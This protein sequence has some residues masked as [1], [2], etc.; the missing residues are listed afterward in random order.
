MGAGD[1]THLPKVLPDKTSLLIRPGNYVFGPF[2]ANDNSKKKYETHHQTSHQEDC[3]MEV[4]ENCVVD[5]IAGYDQ[6]DYNK[7]VSIGGLIDGGET[8]YIDVLNLN[9]REWRRQRAP[10]M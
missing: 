2:I 1:M 9:T 5:L 6:S 10:P 4:S 8:D 3:C 7:T